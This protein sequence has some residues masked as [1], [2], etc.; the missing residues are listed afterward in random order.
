MSEGTPTPAEIITAYPTLAWVNE[1]TLTVLA[2]AAALLLWERVL[3]PTGD[4]A[5]TVKEAACHQVAAWVEAGT[6][7]DLAGY[8]RDVTVSVDGLTVSGQPAQV[9]P[10]ALRVLRLAGL[11]NL[12]GA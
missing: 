7:T 1:G 4:D 5:L 11:L 8:N 12:P 10:R 3:S 9:S 6:G 2:D